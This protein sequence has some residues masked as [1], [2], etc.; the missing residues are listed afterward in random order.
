[1]VNKVA[2]NSKLQMIENYVKSVDCISATRVKAPRLFQ[3]K[4]Y[5]KIIDIHFLQKNMNTSINSSIMKDII[6]KNHI[7]NNIMLTSKSCIIKVSPK[8]DMVII[9]IDI[10]DVQS[11]SK[12]KGL[13][14]RYFNVGSFI[15]TI[16]GTNMNLG[17]PSV[18]IVRGGAIPSSCAEFRVPSM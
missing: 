6:K 13:I 12:V 16:R 18:K 7:F 11:S 2:F 3:S 15:T 14:N 17:I 1:M 9:W 4:S 5:L 8:L 10:W